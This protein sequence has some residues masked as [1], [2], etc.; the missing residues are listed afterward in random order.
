MGETALERVERKLDE[1][2]NIVIDLRLHAA[3]NFVTR[4]EFAALQTEA[5]AS[6]RWA[7]G[8]TIASVGAI[9]AAVS[10]WF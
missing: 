5:K 9:A 6:R 10:V 8:T 7:L 1:L 3:S 4:D 2:T